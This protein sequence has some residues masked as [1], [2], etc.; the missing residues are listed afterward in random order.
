[1]S[2]SLGLSGGSTSPDFQ[3]RR[4]IEGPRA[5]RLDFLDSIYACTNHGWKP[6][7]FDGNWVG[8]GT[9][10]SP[11]AGYGAMPML[12]ESR[13]PF[14]V[15][16]RQRRPSDP[17]RLGR[18]IVNAFTSLTLDQFPTFKCNGDLDSEDYVGALV[19]AVRFPVRAVQARTIGGATGTVGL[20]WVIKNG[21][22]IVRV[23][24]PKNLHVHAWADRDDLIPEHVT[25]MYKFPEQEWNP[26]TRKMEEKWYWFRR[27]WTPVA[28]VVFKV[29]PFE[30]NKD[31]LWEVDEQ[32]SAVHNSGETHFVWVQNY[33]TSDDIDGIC[34]Y[35]ALEDNLE[36]LDI[37]NSLVSRSLNMNLDPTLV[38]AMDMA[39]L[40]AGRSI[41]KGSDQALV[42]GKGGGAQYLELAGS[43]ITVGLE[44]LLASTKHVCNVAQCVLTDPNE[45]AAQGMSGAAIRLVYKPM[46][47]KAAVV[48]E[49]Y[50][51]GFER[52]LLQ[53][54]RTARQLQTTQIAIPQDIGEQT[55][56]ERF[57]QH[58]ENQAPVFEDDPL[59]AEAENEQPQ[60]EDDAPDLDAPEQQVVHLEGII[61]LP[62]KCEE[63]T[64]MDPVT[65]EE[66]SVT[67]EH[68][69]TPGFAEYVESVW[70]PFF[71][72]SV[73][74]QSAKVTML[75][76]ATGGKPVVSQQTAVEQG[77]AVLGVDPTEEWE[78]VQKD[79]KE[80]QARMKE[81]N[82]AMMGGGFGEDAGGEVPPE[83][84][85]A[86]P[87]L[88][89]AGDF[90][91][92]GA[93]DEDL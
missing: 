18:L 78:R 82:A 64:E 67:V 92:F 31:P 47:A 51:D 87:G 55:E 84:E 2:S 85:A 5:M 91:Q 7:D 75:Q 20:S 93:E 30:K 53:M 56:D 11:S 40:I 29:I 63:M 58:E 88:R 62:A 44:R 73:D 27:D 69:R 60:Q 52:V 90:S 33:P 24:N 89:G 14:R 28:D 3:A 71:P 15:P 23:H 81:Q 68:P 39:E 22:P 6:V 80:D 43:S 48:R 74:E 8:Q 26:D 21:K 65:G 61:M 37:L 41:Q 77:A 16:L 50:G 79:T 4:V 10:G 49:Q 38:L 86:P 57:L 66:T 45:L 46:T 12:G 25:E 36:G 9:S 72:D 17:Y 76:T 70:P 34:D 1:M 54:L 59:A 19:K 35:A 32:R 42:V 13:T 83:G